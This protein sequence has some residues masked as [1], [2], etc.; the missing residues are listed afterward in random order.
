MRNITNFDLDL[1]EQFKKIYVLVSGGIDSTYLLELIAAKFPEKTIAVN[2]YNPY[3][4]NKTLKVI[5]SFYPYIAVKPNTSYK[6][7]DIIK[8]AFLNIPGAIELR[9]KKKY[10]KKIFG[11]CRVFKH[12]M[13]KKDPRFREDNT[14]VISGIKRGDGSQRMS[15]L[16]QLSMGKWIIGTANKPNNYYGWARPTFLHKH[17]WGSTYCYPFRDYTQREIP[18][19]IIAE[20]RLKYPTLNHS[21][22]SICPVLIVFEDLISKKGSKLDLERIERSKKYYVKI[23]E[24]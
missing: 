24:R 6:P 1:L 4:R 16:R 11:C 22:C 8:K 10:H 18:D 5:S 15:F 9:K 19:D 3:E 2:C 17:K 13:F 7:A 20:L 23:L 21:G 14:V 12:S